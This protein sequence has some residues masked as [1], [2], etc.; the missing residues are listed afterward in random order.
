MP[1]KVDAE[2]R[3]KRENPSRFRYEVV[4]AGVKGGRFVGF[5]FHRREHQNRNLGL[6]GSNPV[7]Q[8]KTISRHWVGAALRFEVEFE[9]DRCELRFSN[10]AQ[11]GLKGMGRLDV[12]PE[13]PERPAQFRTDNCFIVHEK[14]R[15]HCTPD[16]R[17]G[18]L[19]VALRVVGVQPEVGE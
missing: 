6:C 9:E 12:K 4:G 2:V 1:A 11:S 3:N 7:N 17:N 16:F 15:I 13:A 10:R 8:P 18:D 19:L 5:P 14:Y